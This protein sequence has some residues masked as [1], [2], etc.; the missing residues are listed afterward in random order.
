[1]AVHGGGIYATPE[2]FEKT[3]HA[4]MNRSNTQ[5]FTG[6]YAGKISEREAADILKGKLPNGTEIPVYAF[7]E[8]R[9]G[10]AGLP[11]RYAVVMDFESVR[12]SKSGYQTFDELKEEPLMI[13]RA[14]GIEA[15]TG[16]GTAITRW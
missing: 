4:D 5:G 13:V 16:Q 3:F 7:D 14:G 10:V 15:A 12:K 8:F 6:Q 11:R 9:Q 1:M 2:R